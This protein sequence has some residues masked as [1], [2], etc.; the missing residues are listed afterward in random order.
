MIVFLALPRKW[1]IIFSQNTIIALFLTQK[2][3]HPK[4]LIRNPI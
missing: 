3:Y 4:Y 1:A 2:N